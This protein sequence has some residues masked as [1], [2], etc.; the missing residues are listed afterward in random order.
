MLGHSHHECPSNNGV[1]DLGVMYDHNFGFWLRVTSPHRDRFF[2]PG[3]LTRTTKLDGI[4]YKIPRKEHDG[5]S[6]RIL[7]EDNCGSTHLKSG[8]V[9]TGSLAKGKG[10]I[11]SFVET[12]DTSFSNPLA[13]RDAAGPNKRYA[14]DSASCPNTLPSPAKEVIIDFHIIKHLINVEGGSNLFLISKCEELNSNVDTCGR[15]EG[16]DMEGSLASEVDPTLT[17]KDHYLA[18]TKNIECS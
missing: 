17:L 8:D 15:F 1:K 12:I 10:K 7:V 14:K 18:V 16:I 13:S 9:T 4:N 6:V 3:R 11:V 2:M 5:D